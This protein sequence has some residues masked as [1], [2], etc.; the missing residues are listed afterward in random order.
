MSPG[1]GPW[2]WLPRSGRA[3]GRRAPRRLVLEQLED[4]TLLSATNIGLNAQTS[5][6]LTAPGQADTYVLTVPQDGL[7]TATVQAAGIPT[8]LSLSDGNG[9]LLIQS[10]GQSL[11]NADDLIRQHLQGSA[12]GT[13]Y[14]LSVA[15]LD[16]ATGSFVL[17]TQFQ[18]VY[19][20]SSPVP[21]GTED[22]QVVSAD[23]NGDGI[24]DLAVSN[25]APHTVRILLGTGNGT[26]RA[27]SLLP[28]V[29]GYPNT[30]AVGDFN[31][32]GT[33]DLVV[34]ATGKVNTVTVFLGNGDGTFQAEPAIPLKSGLLAFAVADLNGDGHFDLIVA[35]YGFS[36]VT[37]L[38]GTGDGTFQ[39]GPA[40]PSPGTGLC[41]VVVG[42]FNRDGIPDVALG[43]VYKG[44]RVFLG[45]GDGTFRAAGPLISV[46]IGGSFLGESLVVGDFNR[47]GIPDLAACEIS[48]TVTPLLG[49]GDGTFRV[50][51]PIDSGAA[52]PLDMVTGDFNGD[53]ITDLALADNSGGA[54]VVVFG[55]ADGSFR[56]GGTPVPLSNFP[57][58]LAVGDFNGDGRPDIAAGGYDTVA[59]VFANGDGTFRGSQPATPAGAEPTALATGD[60]NGDGVPD[61]AVADAT[62]NGVSI[63]LG[64]GDG[65]FRAAGPVIPTGRGP[66]G[67]AVGDFN[68]DGRLDLAVASPYDNNITILLGAGDGT[69]RAAGPPIPVDG[70]PAAVAVGDFNSD[71]IPDLAVV[72]SFFAQVPTVDLFFGNGDGTFRA[73]GTLPG[74]T[75]TTLAGGIAAADF[76]GDGIPDLAVTLTNEFDPNFQSAVAIF[77]GTGHGGFR[78]AG[79]P[80]T[81]NLDQPGELAVADFNGDGVPDLAVAAPDAGF[82]LS[83]VEVLPGVGDG[84]FQPPTLIPMAGEGEPG[85]LAVGDFNGDGIPDLAGGG[86][87]SRSVTVLLGAGNGSYLPAGVV[88]DSAPATPLLADFN[89]DGVPDL[90]ILRGDGRILF[91]AGR[92]NDPG[93]FD[94]P[95]IVNPPPL[96]SGPDFPA[97]DLAVVMV[98]GRPE[99]A[100][101]DAHDGAIS[102]YAFDPATGAFTRTASPQVPGL[103]PAR[104]AAGDLN[105]DGRGDLVVTAA[106][107]N[108]VFIYLQDALGKFPDSPS[109]TVGVGAS[110][111][112]IQLAD[113]NGDGLPDILITNQFSGDVSVLLNDPAAPF[114]QELRFRA[115]SDP[116]GLGQLVPSAATTVQSLNDPV[117]LAAGD[118]NGDGKT[119]VVVLNRFA[120]SASVLQ[121]DGSGGLLNPQD[122]LTFPA[123]LDPE[124][125]AVADFNCDGVPDLAVLD[126]GTGTIN[127]FLGQKDGEFTQVGSVS[128]G[129]DPT[130]LAVADVNG[131]GEPDL[132]VGN[133]FGDVLVLLGSPR[134]DGTFTQPVR[135]DHSMGLAVGGGPGG[136]VA[137][138][139]DHARDRLA[140]QST[141]S[142]AGV[143]QSSANGVLAPGAVRF[144]A[145]G[146]TRYVVVANGGGNDVLVYQVGADGLPE[147]GTR[148]VF[149]AGT[150]PVGITVADVNGDGIP[151]VITANEGSNDVSILL[152]QE[153]PHGWTLT[154]GPRLKTGLGPTST[155]VV[156]VPG[157][158]FPALVVSN[159]Q[160]NNVFELPGRGQGFFDDRRPIVLPA[161]TQPVQVVGLPGTDGVAVVNAGSNDITIIPDLADPSRFQVLGSG[162]VEPRA[163]VVGDF[164]GD[165][166]PD[167]AV[168]NNGDGVVSLLL[169]GAG[170]FRDGGDFRFAD[171]EHPTDL[172]AVQDG[173]LLHVYGAGEGREAA[174]LLFTFAVAPAAE[175]TA[176]AQV[177]ELRA[178]ENQTLAVTA[179]LLSV[180]VGDEAPATAPPVAFLSGP[181]GGLGLES[182]A[183]R[184]EA[185]PDPVSEQDPAVVGFVTGVALQG[186][187]GSGARPLDEFPGHDR[188]VTDN[189][190]GIAPAALVQALVETS[191]Q[192][193]QNTIRSVAEALLQATGAAAAQVAD[194]FTPPD[195]LPVPPEG[196]GPAGEQTPVPAD[197]SRGTRLD[198]PEYD[199]PAGEGAVALALAFAAGC[200]SPRR[201]L[202]V[203]RADRCRAACRSGSRG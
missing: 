154:Y 102:L 33:P 74:I 149:F 37:V 96:G 73:G 86:F 91:R 81:L 169:G 171:L 119:D 126:R 151:D 22:S 36:T 82:N 182:G 123:G 187:G 18:A 108:Q 153:T 174:V 38:L 133:G 138:L 130:G 136:D 79:P 39:A 68:G 84:T 99:L 52:D 58:S 202:G 32:D 55:N 172:A 183:E 114:T 168:A 63:L 178:L 104:L 158:P 120:D 54:V 197:E 3:R 147:A 59:L 71:G 98:D 48:G 15:G 51:R 113:V 29:S 203:T 7:L 166:F 200:L 192:T 103:L 107:S 35:N 165:G 150:D 28:S 105:G 19:S 124:A 143:F 76:N 163:A 116:F 164:N 134:C 144:V 10:D 176:A 95:I 57:I 41:A 191:G 11:T 9:H 198:P 196:D 2:S 56:S 179:L 127:I 87:S 45:A 195:G 160:S 27:A 46:A 72:S 125:V 162:G 75:G 181:G 188:A 12:G 161:G 92:A 65:T 14:L 148:Q 141:G 190:F 189:P 106:G 111:F 50:G 44:V 201:D 139:S 132:L 142:G 8:R 115:G 6:L 20:P 109:Y 128:A 85:P 43:T 69:F 21:V 40:F 193:M 159:S 88:S 83:G 24:P 112:A 70:G 175:L 17:T 131:N 152:G 42:D 13:T 78:S 122:A 93:S 66:Y 61:L 49:A 23:F 140:V 89:G 157:Q 184:K 186:H 118:F 194:Q 94:P 100:A 199:Q 34:G 31:G 62:S 129:N 173:N 67:V 97:R 90:A 5:G 60:F 80:V 101:L 170:G 185:E 121:G 167:L 4:R 155:A 25:Y 77:L 47:D 64:N 53:G 26:F 180:D 135:V 110:P 145:V 137:I 156:N 1:F 30:L 177:P 16:G 146:G 117:A